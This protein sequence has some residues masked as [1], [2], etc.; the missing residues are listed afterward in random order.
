MLNPHLK[1]IYQ[2]FEQENNFDI[3]IAVVFLS[4]LLGMQQ[5]A[6]FSEEQY[7]ACEKCMA[8]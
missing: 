5:L 7:S 4:T 1:K 8:K 6:L 2:N 3:I